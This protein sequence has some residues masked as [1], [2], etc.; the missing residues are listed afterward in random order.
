MDYTTSEGIEAAIIF[1]TEELRRLKLLLT[2]QR[3][4][5][6]T[7]QQLHE[8]YRQP[9]LQ[10]QLQPAGGAIVDPLPPA[11][12]VLP[13]AMGWAAAAVDLAAA[14]LDLKDAKSLTGPAG[15]ITIHHARTLHGSALNRSTRDRQML[16]YEMMAA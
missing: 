14:G 12:Y 16:F 4:V 15:T 3:R 6:Q 7:R 5:E 13:E 2:Q 9:P 10:P 1:R 8:M 11:P